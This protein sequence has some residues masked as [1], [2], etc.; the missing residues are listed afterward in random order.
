[1][2]VYVVE[3]EER[4]VGIRQSLNAAKRMAARHSGDAS[5]QLE[6]H[7]SRRNRNEWRAEVTYGIK[8]SRHYRVFIYNVP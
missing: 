6:W 7:H 3:S 5:R 8:S 4:L 1:V 2:K